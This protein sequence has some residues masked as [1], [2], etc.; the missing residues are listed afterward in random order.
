MPSLKAFGRRWNI[1]S[2]DF[3]FPEI[4]E[5]F[6]R[7]AWVAITCGIF[8]YH[9]PFK[10]KSI[11]WF[12]YVM[13]LVAINI[14]TAILC[15]TLASFSARGSILETDARKHVTTLIY[16]RL[17]VL[18]IEF[19][20]AIFTTAFVFRVFGEE[21]FC[22]FIY[23]MRVTVVLEWI[24]IFSVFFGVIVVFNPHGDRRIDSPMIERNYWRKRLRLCKVGADSEMRN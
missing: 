19:V 3:V 11:S 10:C 17:P 6:V 16:V 23:G 15:F 20:W 24:L 4:T 5:G 9:N 18:L 22:Y 2:D 8:A 12:I 13:I 14:I 21:D 1:A 7:L